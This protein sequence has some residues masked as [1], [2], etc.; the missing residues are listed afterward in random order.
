LRSNSRSGEKTASKLK[1]EIQHS[2]EI[3]MQ[4]APEAPAMDNLQKLLPLIDKAQQK[5]VAM[6]L[7]SKN[8]AKY[9]CAEKEVKDIVQ[10][11]MR[12]IK[13]HPD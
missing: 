4:A 8:P 9:K 7:T 12:A 1:K 2:K 6:P 3:A 13:P 10:D 5:A 11:L